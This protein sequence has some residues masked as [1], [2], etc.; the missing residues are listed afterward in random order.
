MLFKRVADSITLL[1]GRDED[2]VTVM[3]KAVK[4]PRRVMRL[5]L[6]ATPDLESRHLNLC[7]DL[8]IRLSS[9]SSITSPLAFRSALVHVTLDFVF[10]MKIPMTEIVTFHAK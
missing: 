8:I 2:E 9:S 4:A 5:W 6:P 10:V 1:T 3:V 7:E